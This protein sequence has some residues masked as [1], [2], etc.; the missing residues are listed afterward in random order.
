[1]ALRSEG[2]PGVE[3]K[4][5]MSAAVRAELLLF[6]SWPKRWALPPEKLQGPVDKRL[7]FTHGTCGAA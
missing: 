6:L 2:G 3:Q 5:R 7:G 1:M 4:E